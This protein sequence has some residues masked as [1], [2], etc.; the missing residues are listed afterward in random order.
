MSGPVAVS[1]YA[2]GATSIC[3]LKVANQLFGIDT[4]KIR[5]VLGTTTPQRVPLA[6]G[7]I[8]GV[9]PY[10]GEVLTTVSLRALLGV[11]ECSGKNCVLVFDSEENEERFGLMVDSVGGVVAMDANALQTN[12]GGLDARSQELFDGTLRTDSGLMVHLDPQR[13]GPSHLAASEMFGR[14]KQERQGDDR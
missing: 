2:G 10:R 7:F 13:L 12:P 5:E 1:S 14:S 9:V 4:S 8:A 3:S 6:P 11:P